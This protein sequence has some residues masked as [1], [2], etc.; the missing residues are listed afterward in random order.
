MGL[1][2]NPVGNLPPELRLDGTLPPD[3]QGFWLREQFERGALRDPELIQGLL[4]Q[5][6]H[7]SLR[8]LTA[9][10]YCAHCAHLLRLPCLLRSLCS[11]C[12]PHPLRQLGAA[13]PRAGHAARV[14][15]QGPCGP[16]YLGAGRAQPCRGG[17]RPP[18]RPTLR[19]TSNAASWRRGG[20]VW[21]RTCAYAHG[22]GRPDRAL[23][24]AAHEREECC[25]TDATRAVSCPCTHAHDVQATCRIHVSYS[26]RMLILWFLC[27]FPWVSLLSTPAAA[28][29]VI[30]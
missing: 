28:F 29:F 15:S 27:P 19:P 13:Q 16:R 5:A 22:A 14:R 1:L 20:H 24:S 4:E 11:L 25:V 10:T 23:H 30:Y 6:R 2:P 8:S 7:S 3:A 9:L 18:T 12:L 17:P 21:A 26:T